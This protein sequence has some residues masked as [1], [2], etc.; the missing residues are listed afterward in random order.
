MVYFLQAFPMR[1]LCCCS[2]LFV[3]VIVICAVVSSHC[4]FFIS[5]SFGASRSLYFV[6]VAFLGSFLYIFTTL[7]QCRTLRRNHPYTTLETWLTSIAA[8][9]SFTAHG[10]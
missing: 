2:F 10:C 6:I 4:L 8:K 5:S 1:F 7:N 3:E 9:L